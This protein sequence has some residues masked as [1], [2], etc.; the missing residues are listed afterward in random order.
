MYE[1]LINYCSSFIALST[2]DK[3]A[4]ALNFKHTTIKRNDF[5][6]KEG[7]VCDFIA[8]LNSGVIRHYH[9]KDGKEI[10]CDVTLKNSF[11]TDFKSFTQSSPSDYNFQIL[12]NA[13]LFII[14]KKELS[15]LYNNYKN[16]ESLGRIMAEQVALRAIDIAKSLSSD[17]PKDRV[18]KLIFQ[19]PDLFQEVPQR[20]LANL[21]GISP[22][23]LSRI[24][25]R[26]N[27]T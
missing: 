16:I 18:E 8:Y 26:K 19:R 5:L 1:N 3:E 21:I 12:K 27:L 10:T 25:A 17:K 7:K 4:I 23:S 11:I 22:E 2:I 14:K 24:R 13:D 20:Y 15:E 6:L 9:L